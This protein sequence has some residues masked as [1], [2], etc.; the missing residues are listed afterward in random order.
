M[1][2][3]EAEGEGGDCAPQTTILIRASERT[4]LVSA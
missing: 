1:K 4:I 3:G 2:R